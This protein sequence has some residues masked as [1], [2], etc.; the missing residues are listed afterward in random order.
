VTNARLDQA[1]AED[2]ITGSPKARLD[3]AL[4]E[5]IETGSPKA[6][7]D[8]VLAEQIETG[9]PNLRLDQ[10][11]VEYII[12]YPANPLIPTAIFPSLPASLGW[13]VHRRPTNSTRVAA[14][15][16]G[17]EVRSPYYAMPLYEFELTYDGLL[18]GA[19]A[20]GA[21]PA[22]TLQALE[23]FFLQMQ[24]QYGGFLFADPENCQ[25]TGGALGTGDGVTTTFLMLRTVGNYS[26]AIQDANV[27]TAVYLNGV[28]QSGG[29]WSV[30]NGNQIVFSTAPGAGVTV[31][32][33]FSYYFVCRFLDD[34]QD[35]EEFLYQLHT[36]KS[37]KFRTVR[38]S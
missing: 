4:A 18:S 24:G 6:R 12:S 23:G 19:S 20:M 10:A 32:A 34:V 36:L 9:S 29:S 8:Q 1:L 15:V 35:Y 22:Q 21:I 11:L 3:Q 28:A 14:A 16:N 30:I 13:S 7:L 17:R 5:Q 33:D 26:E 38:T 25:V 31:T 37:C 27:V 2:V